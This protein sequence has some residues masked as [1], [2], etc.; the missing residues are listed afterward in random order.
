MKRVMVL[1]L[2]VVMF[3]FVFAVPQ[4][5]DGVDNDGDGFKD[6]LE[7][8]VGGSGPTMESYLNQK[9]KSGIETVLINKPSAY[10]AGHT[11]RVE[12]IS[13]SVNYQGYIS[14]GGVTRNFINRCSDS[15]ESQYVG[16]YSIYRTIDVAYLF[17]KSSS[18]STISSVPLRELTESTV[19]PIGTKSITTNTVRPSIIP[20]TP[21][22]PSWK[23]WN[24]GECSFNLIVD[25][26]PV[27]DC[28]NGVDDNG[29][30]KFDFCDGSNAGTCDSGC[31]FLDDASEY[32]HDLE[33][34]SAL[35]DDELCSTGT[36]DC[37]LDGVSCEET[38]SSLL[39]S[40]NN[41]GVCGVSCSVAQECSLGSCVDLISGDNT[42]TDMNG[43][44]ITTASI[45]SYVKMWSP[46]AGRGNYTIYD[47]GEVVKN[48]SDFFLQIENS[49]TDLSFNVSGELENEPSSGT[50]GVTPSTDNIPMKITVI[51]PV[52]GTDYVEGDSLR[53]HLRL[54]DPDDIISGNISV[55]G[56]KITDF[57]NLNDFNDSLPGV[58]FYF[59][60]IFIDSGNV[61]IL[62]QATNTNYE[63]YREVVNVIVIDP[64]V[65]DVYVASCIDEPKNFDRFTSSSVR[66]RANSTK[67]LN[68]TVAD[69]IELIPIDDL[70]FTWTFFHRGSQTFTCTN[71]GRESCFAAGTTTM[72][73]FFKEFSTVEENSA[74]LSVSIV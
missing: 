2:F 73:D 18:G 59:D 60:Y 20:T 44:F 38:D 55:S 14:K 39:A 66:F 71:L 15:Y 51:N 17:F 56:V 28:S 46:W 34:S 49:W 54:E 58:D 43:D 45:G 5:S 36:Y 9:V 67:A 61:Q 8:F 13:G 12:D 23:Q 24:G 32:Q 19:I 7:L 26:S 35:D 62:V 16:S 33:C 6:Y 50:L 22:G 30:G 64:L 72:Y 68:Y 3:S 42:W 37:D 65:D 29:D 53:M 74:V 52:C 70:E 11:I 25:E 10:D 31:A 1:A 63:R 4:C 27:G 69:G 48:I 47:E 41:C 57:T 40:V 21:W